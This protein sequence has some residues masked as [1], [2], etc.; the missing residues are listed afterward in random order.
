MATT[1]KNLKWAE[2]LADKQTICIEEL[3]RVGMVSFSRQHDGHTVDVLLTKVTVAELNGNQVLSVVA[4][5]RRDG[6]PLEVDNPLLYVNPPIC[7]PDGTFEI[8]VDTVIGD[9]LQMP[10]Y[11]ESPDD[12]LE[13]IVFDTIVMTALQS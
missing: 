9:Q 2:T 5:A 4:S 12:A 6:V 13:V 3:R 10:N 8:V 11:I 1:L 7:V